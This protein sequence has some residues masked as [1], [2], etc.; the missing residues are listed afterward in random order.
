MD[1]NTPLQSAK[2]VSSKHVCG[3]SLA[4]V[5]IMGW[6]VVFCKIIRQVSCYFLL[7][8]NEVSLADAVEHP[9]K[10]HIDGLGASLFNTIVG[11]SSGALVVHLHGH[12]VVGEPFF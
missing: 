5:L 1:V 8:D 4:H 7:I 3:V 12:A 6:W 2:K 10:Y 11:E 9:V